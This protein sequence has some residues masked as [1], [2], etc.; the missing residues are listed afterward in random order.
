MFKYLFVILILLC[1]GCS[2]TP[3]YDIVIHELRQE[4]SLYN[5]PKPESPFKALYTS[6]SLAEK[7]SKC[8]DNGGIPR[9]TLDDLGRT[10]KVECKYELHSVVSP[11]SNKSTC[12]RGY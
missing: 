11:K 2:A 12:H 6:T 7:K 10:K 8:V 5:M 4:R 3:S 1:F 9:V